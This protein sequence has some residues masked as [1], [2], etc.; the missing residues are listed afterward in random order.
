M[1]MEYR[2]KDIACEKLCAEIST[3]DF[4]AVAKVCTE[5]RQAGT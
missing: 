1:K 5:S 2:N 3:C 4:W